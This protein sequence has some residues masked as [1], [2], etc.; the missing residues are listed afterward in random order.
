MCVCVIG[1]CGRPRAESRRVAGDCDLLQLREPA[2]V[3]C[4]WCVSLHSLMCVK[5]AENKSSFVTS[6]TPAPLGGRTTSHAKGRLYLPICPSKKACAE[7]S[8][9]GN[10]RAVAKPS[11]AHMCAHSTDTAPTHTTHTHTAPTKTVSDSHSLGGSLC[12]STCG[13]YTWAG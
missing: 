13:L 1:V 8:S 12:C 5:F 9:A 7:R 10:L 6:P 2:A 4:V 11:S 3:V